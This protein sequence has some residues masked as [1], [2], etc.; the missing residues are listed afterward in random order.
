MRKGDEVLQVNVQQQATTKSYNTPNVDFFFSVDFSNT[1]EG[2]SRGGRRTKVGSLEGG[3]S[4]KQ[5]RA[6]NDIF[7]QTTTDNNM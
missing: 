5:L 3:K 7:H 2:L 6:H 4:L 1:D